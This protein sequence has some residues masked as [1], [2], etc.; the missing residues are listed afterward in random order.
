MQEL[1]KEDPSEYNQRIAVA[2]M[3]STPHYNTELGGQVLLSMLNLSN[4]Y[5]NLSNAI[6]SKDDE[7]IDKEKSS[8]KNQMEI[9]ILDLEEHLGSYRDETTKS[10]IETLAWLATDL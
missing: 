8:L 3:H 5:V 9:V 1:Q 4:E 6:K 2:I 10:N 7:V